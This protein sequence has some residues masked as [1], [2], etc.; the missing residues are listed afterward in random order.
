[1][2][3]T[4]SA[5]QEASAWT[6]GRPL[7]V[8]EWS[9][10]ALDSGLP[11]THGAGQRF[12][13][14]DQRTVASELCARTMMAAPQV[15]G[16]SYF[17]W[18]DQPSSGISSAFREDSNYGVN[19]I[20]GNVY[21]TLTDMFARVQPDRMRW[22]RSPPPEIK[23][24]LPPDPGETAAMFLAKSSELSG[25]G[26]RCIFENGVFCIENSVG[27]RI[28]GYV[29]GSNAIER[30]VYG[31]KDFGTWNVMLCTSHDNDKKMWTSATKITS[32]GFRRSSH[33]DVLRVV[34]RN[35]VFP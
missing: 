10:P 1:M 24:P 5:F 23:P 21:R 12:L 16:Y 35:S 18:T 9:F 19:T 30:I 20:D 33:G 15:V 6:G 27:L 26:V 3:L 32:A 34:M 2:L 4:Q 7:I 8:S 31:Q 25:T 22:R 29:G 11:C 13:T 28:E 17:K 14:Q